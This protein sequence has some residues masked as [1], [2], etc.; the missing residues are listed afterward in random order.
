[1]GNMPILQEMSFIA[2]ISGRTVILPNF[3][4]HASVPAK[5]YECNLYF[6]ALMDIFLPS[7]HVLRARRSSQRVIFTA[8][9]EK[10]RDKHPSSTH[11]R[12]VLREMMTM[13]LPDK[14]DFLAI[15]FSFIIDNSTNNFII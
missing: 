3:N 13:V 1:M 4:P 8:A 9:E 12:V 6:C 5:R 15:S 14:W 2:A 10:K 11:V 7:R